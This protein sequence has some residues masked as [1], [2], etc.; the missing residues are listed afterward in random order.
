LG[1]VSAINRRS[2]ANADW[3]KPDVG[4]R[5]SWSLKTSSEEGSAAPDSG[6]GGF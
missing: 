4:D 2:Y 5:P 1:A 6:P 3:W